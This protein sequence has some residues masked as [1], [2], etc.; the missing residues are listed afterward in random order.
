MHALALPQ[1]G[2]G[3]LRPSNWS[4]RRSPFDIGAEVDHDRGRRRHRLAFQADRDIG[5]APGNLPSSSSTKM[6]LT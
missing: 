6:P 5:R 1:H 4:A 2:V 3:D